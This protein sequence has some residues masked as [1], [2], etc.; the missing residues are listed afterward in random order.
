MGVLAVQIPPFRLD[1]GAHGAAHIGA[2]VMGQAAL[3]HGAVDHVRG[4]FHQAALIGVLNAQDEGAV[5]VAGDEPGIQ[6]G[7]QIAHVHVAGGRGGETGADRSLRNPRFHLFKKR[8]VECH[9]NVP[10]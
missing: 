3:G 6:S 1:I 10:P 7:A 9:E 5:V 8:L 2:F 4:A